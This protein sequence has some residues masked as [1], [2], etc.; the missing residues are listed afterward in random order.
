M[1]LKPENSSRRFLLISQPAHAW[2]SGQFA[3]AWGNKSFS[4]FQPFEQVCFAAEQH[5]V[6]FLQ[7]ECEPTLNETT[8][9]PFTFEDLPEQLHFDIWRTGISQLRPICPY[10]SLIVSMHFSTLCERYHNPPS[11]RNDSECGRYLQEQ[12]ENR[13]AII[14]MLR[15]DHLLEEALKDLVLD[16]HRNLL[17]TWD[18]L[19]LQLCRGRSEE[20]I[21]PQVPIWGG[22]AHDI[23]V[24]KIGK[25]DNIWQLEPWPFRE[26]LLTTVCEAKLISGRFDDP[27]KMQEALREADRI[28]LEFRF[29][30][31]S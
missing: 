5:D 15:T 6:G 4:R 11:D 3:R 17:A 14:R 10:A 16:Y 29:Q 9:L 22:G 21:L 13:E 8:G 31:A 24:R 7:W 19:S 20:F 30:A 28:T 2:M 26:P 23:L 25:T 12:Q 27:K 1:I 18:L